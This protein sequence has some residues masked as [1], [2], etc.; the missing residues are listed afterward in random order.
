[1]PVMPEPDF[2]ERS[3]FA[4]RT[5]VAALCLAAVL[6]VLVARLTYWALWGAE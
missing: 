1:M 3:P 6:V 2:E 4:L 5:I